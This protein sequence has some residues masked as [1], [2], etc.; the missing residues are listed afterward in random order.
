MKSEVMPTSPKA[1][2]M[3]VKFMHTYL[4]EAMV[5]QAE[6]MIYEVLSMKVLKAGVM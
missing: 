1:E 5:K 6:A 2:V 3:R 4:M